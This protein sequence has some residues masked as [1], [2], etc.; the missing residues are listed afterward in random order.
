[1]TKCIQK[2]L[3]IFLNATILIVLIKIDGFTSHTT[4]YVKNSLKCVHKNFKRK[5][6]TKCCWFISNV[7]GRG[8]GN[9]TPLRLIWKIISLTVFCLSTNNIVWRTIE[10]PGKN[11]VRD[12]VFMRPWNYCAVGKGRASEYDKKEKNKIKQYDNNAMYAMCCPHN[13]VVSGRGSR[14]R[15]VFSC[16]DRFSKAI[17]YPG[18]ERM[19]NR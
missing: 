16:D 17:I 4:F 8:K 5:V 7:D 13:I 15:R 12:G 9:Y 19:R 14:R 11:I 18:A 6:Q 1:M 3:F 10:N 2:I